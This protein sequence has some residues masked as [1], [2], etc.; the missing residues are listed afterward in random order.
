MKSAQILPRGMASNVFSF[1][2]WNSGRSTPPTVI[3][4]CVR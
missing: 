1:L 3:G 2:S 4:F